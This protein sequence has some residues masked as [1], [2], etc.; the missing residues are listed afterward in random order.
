MVVEL[1]LKFTD[2]YT[3]GAGD[4]IEFTHTLTSPPGME[5]TGGQ[6]FVERTGGGELDRFSFRVDRDDLGAAKLTILE[7]IGS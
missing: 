6:I 7:E 3:G 5:I 4:P 1:V 2:E